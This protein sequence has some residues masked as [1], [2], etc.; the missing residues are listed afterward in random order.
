[1][2]IATCGHDVSGKREYLVEVGD[3][4]DEGKPCK[5]YPVLCQWCYLEY[6]RENIII[7]TIN[8]MLI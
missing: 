5:A 4:D 6:L 7:K 8:K 2:I 3:F 1:M